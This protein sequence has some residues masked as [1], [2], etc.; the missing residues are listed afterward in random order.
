[1]RDGLIFGAGYYILDSQVQSIAYGWVLT[2]DSVGRD[3]AL[4][5]IDTVPGEAVSK[6]LFVADPQT[7][8]ALA[9][10][11]DTNLLNVSD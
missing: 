7:G 3:A 4:A 8:N 2:Y 11:A 9:Q 5:R 1:M 10:G 6:Y